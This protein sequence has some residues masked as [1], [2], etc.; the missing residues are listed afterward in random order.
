LVQQCRRING[1]QLTRVKLRANQEEGKGG[2]K[3]EKGER[4]GGKEGRGRGGERK[5][6][7]KG[8]NMMLTI[9]EELTTCTYFYRTHK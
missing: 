8:E 4:R 1:L 2:K 9:S 7:R 5:G 3:G 6:V